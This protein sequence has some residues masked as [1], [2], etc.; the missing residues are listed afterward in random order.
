MTVEKTLYVINPNSSETVTS[1]IDAA[2]APLRP[3]GVPIEVLRLKE[4]PPGIET[5][6]QAD[7]V[8][9]P[10]LAEARRLEARP[11]LSDFHSY[12]KRRH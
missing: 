2:M 5:Q 3:L 7:Q 1:E 10:L 6:A 8:V 4:A 9:A 12:L 11:P